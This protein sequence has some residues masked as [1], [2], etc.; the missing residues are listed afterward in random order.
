MP[1][2]LLVFLVGLLPIV[3]RASL[4]WR[5]GATF[6]IR[7]TLVYLFALL[8]ALRYWSPALQT[9]QG[10]LPMDPRFASA[11]VFLALFVP[12]ALVAAL[13]VNLKGPF[14]QAVQPN[15]LDKGLGAVCGILSGLV[16]GGVLVLLCAFVMP[17]TVEGFAAEKLPARFDQL[18]Q[19]F[20]QVVERDVARVSGPAQTVFPEPPPAPVPEKELPK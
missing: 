15:P 5:T 17:G 10:F 3:A 11:G 18:P 1:M 4:G 8:A 13:I 2:E 9:V 7:H 20:F 14:Y 19:K 12:A 6:E 16:L